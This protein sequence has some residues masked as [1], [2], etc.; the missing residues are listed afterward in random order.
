MGRG[1]ESTS[2][3]A[4]KKTHF[5]TRM[6]SGLSVLNSQRTGETK[7][8]FSCSQV[9]LLVFAALYASGPVLKKLRDLLAP[10]VVACAPGFW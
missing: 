9:Q 6:C 7:L 2:C 3:A 10:R 5:R 1:R 4:A 8:I